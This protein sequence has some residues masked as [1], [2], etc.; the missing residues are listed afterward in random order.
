MVHQTHVPAL[1]PRNWLPLDPESGVAPVTV[2]V[3]LLDEDHSLRLA[4]DRLIDDAELR[5]SLGRAGR[6]YWEREHTPARMVD[7][8]VRVITRAAGLPAPATPPSPF[9]HDP[10]ALART[11]L[12]PFGEHAMRITLNGDPFDLP[13]PLS[14]QALLDHLKIDGRMVAV[15]YN[16]VVI[17]RAR[18]ADT[19]VVEGSEVEI[20]AFVGG[21]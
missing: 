6:A 9:D 8:Y 3:D 14:V 10:L 18:Y 1:D 7:D 20:V 11:L 2:A 16:L 12:E 4:L 19:M 21:G 15:E 17:K 13:G 5:A